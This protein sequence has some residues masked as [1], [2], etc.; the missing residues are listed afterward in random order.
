MAVID[1]SA[2]KE[3][4][5]IV[6]TSD[7][8]WGNGPK[9]YVYKNALWEESTRVPLII[10]APGVGSE[11]TTANH[12]VSLIDLFPTLIDLCDLPKDTR[13]T[14]KGLTMDGYSLKPFLQDP[15]TKQWPGPQA[16]LT[17]IHKWN[18]HNPANQSYALRSENWRYIRY[19]TGAEELYDSIND[20][21]E[22]KNLASDKKYQA[23]VKSF[24]SRLDARLS[25]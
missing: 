10:R 25:L 3:N 24:R 14:E 20:P 5:I 8:G 18:D 17:A 6:V 22:W 13:R 9:D 2:L 11:G 4:T 19:H 7:H 21:H 12:P 15:T 16:A 1:N 23:V